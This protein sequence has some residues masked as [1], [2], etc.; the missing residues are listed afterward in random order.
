MAA[1]LNPS[2]DTFRSH[3]YSRPMND[4]GFQSYDSGI[5][6]T[7]RSPRST[8]PILGRG[9]N[10]LGEKYVPVSDVYIVQKDPNLELYA[11]VVFRFDTSRDISGYESAIISLQDSSGNTIS[12]EF[13]RSPINTPPAGSIYIDLD[14]FEN[15][16][17]AMIDFFSY[18]IAN[19]FPGNANQKWKISKLENTD[20]VILK[21]I[22]ITKSVLPTN[23]S[24]VENLSSGIEIES[25]QDSSEFHRWYLD[26]QKKEREDSRAFHEDVMSDIIQTSRIRIFEDIPESYDIK[27]RDSQVSSGA[28]I[29]FGETIEN[30]Y[31][32]LENIRPASGESIGTKVISDE[33]KLGITYNVQSLEKYIES[34]FFD[35]EYWHGSKELD[36]TVLIEL[37]N[38]LGL[39]ADSII[40]L[41]L[42]RKFKRRVD[43]N[44][45]RLEGEINIF[46]DPSL[47][48][49]FSPGQQLVGGFVSQNTMEYHDMS[50]IADNDYSVWAKFTKQASFLDNDGQFINLDNLTLDVPF[51]SEEASY[52]DPLREYSRNS[53]IDNEVLEVIMSVETND[54]KE[55][56]LDENIY[57]STGFVVSQSIRNQGIIYNGLLK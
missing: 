33:Y 27:F 13:V 43:S 10:I 32:S 35:D 29:P 49:L 9:G 39:S 24:I 38:H 42:E 7:P 53:T 52:T 4:L 30:L 40:N 3:V 57:T 48:F 44:H 56:T 45:M 51:V 54:R 41:Y 36:W 22:D 46:N 20:G 23:I 8:M 2:R 21:I 37:Y 19:N 26:G 12:Y 6:I 28:I 11:S 17:I 1:P 31:E 16:P 18:Q 55:F 14:A 34:N 25:F 47:E 5:Y 50:D 15:S